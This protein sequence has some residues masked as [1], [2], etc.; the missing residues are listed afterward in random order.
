MALLMFSCSSRSC[1]C[2]S[3]GCAASPAL[4]ALTAMAISSEELNKLRY[5]TSE[6]PV[7]DSSSTQ[8]TGMASRL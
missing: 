6:G 2:A 7:I 3:S 1:I 4:S 5:S 8:K